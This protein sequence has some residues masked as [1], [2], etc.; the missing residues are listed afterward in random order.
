[1]KLPDYR[2]FGL[3]ALL[4]IAGAFLNSCKTPSEPNVG[5]YPSSVSAIIQKNCNSG[6]CH[7]SATTLNGGLDLST[8][9]AMTNGSILLNDVIPYS[10]VNSHLFGHIN[11]NSLIG[12]TFTPQMPLSLNPLS[13]A[14]QLA[15]F[16][17]INQGAKSE[18]GRVPYNEVTQKIFVINQGDNCVSVLDAV[19]QR[20]VRVIPTIATLPTSVAVVPG[21]Q[22]FIV[23]CSGA[24]GSIRKYDA[25]NYSLVAEFESTFSPS[26]IVITPDG[27]KGYITDEAYSGNRL[28][29]FDPITMSITRTIQTPLIIDPNYL[30]CSPDG[31]YVYVCGHGSDNILRIDTQTDEILKSIPLG[32]DVEVPPTTAYARKYTPEQMVISMDSKTMYVSCLNTSEVV[33]INLTNDSIINRIPVLHN[34]WGLTL[35]PDGLE[36]WVAVWGSSSVEAISTQTNQRIARL[37]STSSLPHA[38]TITPDGRHVIAV[39]ELAAG[40]AHHHGTGGTPP[41]SYVVMDRLTKKIVSVNDLPSL[42]LDITMGYK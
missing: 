24:N 14:D 33:E 42:S 18:D 9:E 5:N 15:I 4:L 37:D 31:K 40:G 13:T 12:P 17:W 27:S 10:A 34:P 36:L 1:M 11:T 32:L 20:L 21:G 22:Y 29:A 6:N 8:W 30:K 2:D 3:L 25:S 28:L 39:C 26:S 19:T 16:N 7:G 38:I 41:S 23:G 35:S